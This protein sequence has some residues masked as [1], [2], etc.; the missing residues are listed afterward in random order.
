MRGLH[1][2]VIDDDAGVRDVVA[3]TLAKCGASVTVASS[4]SD[5]LNLLPNLTPDVVVSDLALPEVDGYEFIR[6]FRNLT[7]PKGESVPAIALTAY[8]SQQD[9]DKALE[10]GFDRHLAKPIDPG[11]LV[12]AIVKTREEKLGVAG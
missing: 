7:K 3:L 9:R 2:M 1:V 10:A 11:E 6:R 4:A 5:A 8:G 12:R